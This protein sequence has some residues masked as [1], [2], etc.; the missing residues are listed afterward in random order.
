MP[1]VKHNN[2][3]WENSAPKPLGIHRGVVGLLDKGTRLQESTLHQI[4]MASTA[5][6]ARCK[7]VWELQQ[8]NHCDVLWW[9]IG[10][11]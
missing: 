5:V 10:M 1:I 2:S 11:G 6:V 3:A 4:Q 7:I 8:Q 9:P